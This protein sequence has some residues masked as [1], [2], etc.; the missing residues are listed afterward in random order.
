[1]SARHLHR[2]RW[3]PVAVLAGLAAGVCAGPARAGDGS[4]WRVVE[5]PAAPGSAEPALVSG[6]DGIVYLSWVESAGAEQAL[7]FATWDGSGWSDPRTVTR[8]D[9]GSAN[10]ANFPSLAALSD[11]TLFAHWLVH[12][13]AD[14]YASLLRVAVSGDGG[15]TWSPPVAPH[16][17]STETEHGFASMAPVDGDRM[18]LIWLDGREMVGKQEGEPGANMTLRFNTVDRNGR[19]G[20]DTLLDSLVCDCCGTALARTGNGSLLAV[21]RDRSPE[22]IRDI[23]RMRLV[24]GNWSEPAAVHADGWKIPGCPVNGPAVASGPGG[25]AAVWFTVAGDEARVWIAFSSDHGATFGEPIQADDGHPLGRVDLVLTS[26]GE[27]VVSWME[28]AGDSAAIRVRRFTPRGPEA[29]AGVSIPASGERTAGFPQ[30]A[31][32]SG[33][34]LVAWTEPGKPSRVRT[35]IVR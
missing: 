34:V 18:G 5:N 13:G 3:L 30:L 17:D 4:S 11:G 27:A 1:M 10:W 14:P 7:R 9:D 2:S 16:R 15:A 6:A 28:S 32:F 23:S 22:E 33:G 21:Y 24:D 31:A 35:A 26:G 12:A 8:G 19:P 25:T 29:D 20:E